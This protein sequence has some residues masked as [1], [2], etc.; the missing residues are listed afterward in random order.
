[1][2]WFKNKYFVIVFGALTCL[3]LDQITKFWVTSTFRS[4]ESLV[5]ISNYFSITLKHNPGAAFGLFR[6][7]PITFFLVVSAIALGFI[8][9]FIIRSDPSRT[10]LSAAH[11]LIMGGAMGNISD[12]VRLGMVVDFLDV[13]YYDWTW[14]TFNVADMAIVAGVFFFMWDLSKHNWEYMVPAPAP[15]KV[16][17]NEPAA[18]PAVMNDDGGN[19]ST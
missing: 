6:G 5:V 14:P 11:S 18:T 4:D 7:Q 12:R 17:S 2:L 13:H 8:L 10:R 3:S 16:E 9:F 15:V 1:M 19:P